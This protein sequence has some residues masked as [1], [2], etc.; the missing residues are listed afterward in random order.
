MMSEQN[1]IIEE[2]RLVREQKLAEHDGDLGSLVR[3]LQR[4]SEDRTRLAQSPEN[5]PTLLENAPVKLS[6]ECILSRIQPKWS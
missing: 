3:E 1:P 4:L 6:A 5:P 2:I